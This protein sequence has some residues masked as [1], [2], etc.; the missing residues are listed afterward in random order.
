MLFNF[1]LVPIKAAENVCPDADSRLVVLCIYHLIIGKR[2]NLPICK[3]TTT[4]IQIRSRVHL[5]F[6][7]DPAL[8]FL[9]LV[10][11]INTFLATDLF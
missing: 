7:Y 10:A 6:T 4:S 3:I 11:V 2:F 8:A 1:E 9:S 5:G